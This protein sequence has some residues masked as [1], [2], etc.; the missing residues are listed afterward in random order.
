MLW[1][2]FTFKSID[3]EQSRLLSLMRWALSNH[4]KALTGWTTILL[5]TPQA[6]SNLQWAAF[7]RELCPFPVL[8]P[9][10]SDSGLTKHLPM[11]EPMPYDK[12]LFLSLSLHVCVSLSPFFCAY[13]SRFVS[14]FISLCLSVPLC[15]SLCLSLS[16]SFSVYLCL[17]LSLSLSIPVCL[18]LSPPC[19][20]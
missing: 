10:S 14:V 1:V 2:R 12:S 6:S 11:R 8:Q 19:S 3:V 13:L 7:R 9:A 4:L 15:V 16:I 18:S 20:G 5:F 17:C